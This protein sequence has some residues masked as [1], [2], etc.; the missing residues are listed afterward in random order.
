MLAEDL[1]LGSLGLA[2]LEPDGTE[3]PSRLAL[4]KDFA[5]AF[6]E[7]RR[8]DLIGITAFAARAYVICPPTFDREVQLKALSR[9]KVGLIKDATAIGSGVMSSLSAL[10][11]VK[12]K[13]KIIILLTD[14]INNF[15]MVPPLAAAEAAKAIGVKIYT[16]GIESRGQ[17]PFPSKDIYG[18]TV[19]K[20]VRIDTDTKTLRKMAAVTGGRFFKVSHLSELRSGWREIEQ[21][22][23]EKMEETDYENMGEAYMYFAWPALC[24]LLISFIL[25]NTVLRRIP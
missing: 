6:I 24:L 1:T 13:S 25:G 22:E 12:A 23:K 11:D 15:G 3:R 19:Y 21:L 4:V 10:Q 2:K 7:D 16:L 17:T 20:N 8:N 18:H 9:I 14:G 5:K